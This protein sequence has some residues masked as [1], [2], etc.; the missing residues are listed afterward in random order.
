MLKQTS[1][2]KGSDSFKNP[3]MAKKKKKKK[4]KAI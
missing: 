4:K 1:F 3:S 2:K